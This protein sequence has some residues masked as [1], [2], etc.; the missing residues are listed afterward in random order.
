[1]SIHL[2]CSVVS[3]LVIYDNSLLFLLCL[4]LSTRY[5]RPVCCYS[6]SYLLPRVSGSRSCWSAGWIKNKFW[7]VICYFKLHFVLT[8]SIYLKRSRFILF[9]YLFVIA[10]VH[11]LYEKQFVGVYSVSYVVDPWDNYQFVLRST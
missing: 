2:L 9:I 8:L 6:M 11:F 10:N 4:F 3:N 5:Y 7:S 1:M